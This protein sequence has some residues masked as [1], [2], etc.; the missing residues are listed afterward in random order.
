MAHPSEDGQLL[1]WCVIDDRRAILRSDDPPAPVMGISG[2]GYQMHGYQE[3]LLTMVANILDDT[4]AI[5]TAGLLREGAIAW[6]EGHLG[7]TKSS[8]AAGLSHCWGPPGIWGPSFCGADAPPSPLVRGFRS[9][10]GRLLARAPYLPTPFCPSR[11]QSAIGSG[12]P[13]QGCRAVTCELLSSE[14][15]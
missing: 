4:L 6:V 13:A 2:P 9:P 8:A 12:R 1:R 3:W 5:N 15:A 7:G 14:V 10:Y 11:S